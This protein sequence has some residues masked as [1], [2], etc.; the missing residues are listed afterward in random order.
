MGNETFYLEATEELDSNRQDPAIW[1]K[2]L[3]LARGEQNVARYKYIELRVEQLESSTVAPDSAAAM[4]VDDI[5]TKATPLRNEELAPSVRSASDPIQSESDRG[6]IWWRVWAWLGLTLGNLVG[7]AY[8]ADVPGPAVVIIAINSMLMIMVLAYNKYA[9]L[10][11]TILSLNP[12]VWLVNG[13]YLKRRWN[14][15]RVNGGSTAS[16]HR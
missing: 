6:F 1:A 4:A 9:F 8:L 11:A 2:A 5:S 3:A 7:F 15:P 14:H 12:L 16:S 13:I 10:I